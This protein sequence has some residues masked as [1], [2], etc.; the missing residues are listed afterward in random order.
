MADGNTNNNQANYN[1][2]ITFIACFMG[3]VASI[4]G[5]MFGYVRY[6]Y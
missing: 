5:F 6:G 1:G 2:K 4:G 3:L